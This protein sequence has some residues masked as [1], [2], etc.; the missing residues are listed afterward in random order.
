MEKKREIFKVF[1]MVVYIIR[2]S[3]FEKKLSMHLSKKNTPAPP[4]QNLENPLTALRYFRAVLDKLYLACSPKICTENPCDYTGFSF[5][6]L[7]RALMHTNF[8]NVN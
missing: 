5:R 6:Q 8:Q 7:L 3:S 2:N 1:R 4:S